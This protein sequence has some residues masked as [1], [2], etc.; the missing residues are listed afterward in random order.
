M[1]LLS[2]DHA[3]VREAARLA[4]L[5]PPSLGSEGLSTRSALLPTP[6]E[7]PHTGVC[8]DTYVVVG[9]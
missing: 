6:A 7:C 8:Y 1:L 5:S 2:A 4:P 9:E 3:A